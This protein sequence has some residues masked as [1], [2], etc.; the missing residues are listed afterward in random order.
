MSLEYK[1]K[2]T[3]EVTLIECYFRHS[4]S[5]NSFKRQLLLLAQFYKLDPEA[6]RD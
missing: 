6:Q 1:I 2:T 5:I 4:S 3:T